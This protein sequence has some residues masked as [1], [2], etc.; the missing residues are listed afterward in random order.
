MKIMYCMA[1]GRFRK[2]RC[3]GLELLLVALALAQRFKKA[4]PAPVFFRLFFRGGM[5]VAGGERVPTPI[6]TNECV[7]LW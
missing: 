2:M 3:A 5:G 4:A 6:R 7:D 1:K